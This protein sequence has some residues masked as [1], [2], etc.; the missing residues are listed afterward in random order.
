MGNFL[1]VFSTY[2]LEAPYLPRAIIA[3]LVC[4]ACMPIHPINR[5]RLLP[6]LNKTTIKTP[7]IF[8]VGHW[9]SGTTYLHQL[10]TQDPEFACVK[11]LQ[12]LAPNAPSNQYFLRNILERSI[13]KKRSIDNIQVS[14][15]APQE[16]DFQISCLS[17]NSFYHA[18]YFPK[19]IR[20]IF[21]KYVLFESFS[22]HAHVQAARRTW[23]KNYT[24]VLRHALVHAERDATLLLK[25]PSNTAR[26]DDLLELFPDAKFIHLYRNPY[27]VFPSTKNLY[28]KFQNYAFQSVDETTLEDDIFYIYQRL[29]GK[30]FEQSSKIPQGNLIHV[31]YEDLE[32]NPL[33]E[34][35]RIYAELAIPDFEN[36]SSRFE[37]HVHKQKHYK[38]NRYRALTKQEVDKIYQHWNFT[39]DQWQY[40]VPETSG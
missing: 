10:L 20:S 22:G 34:I 36:V 40:A 5:A 29:M 4:G 8:I 39:I 16:E 23:V 28:R 25:D 15:D 37:Q 18:Y 38:K 27:H 33:Q 3:S 12:C 13:P 11:L 14:L 6:E 19:H 26:I 35:R 17:K 21:E 2:G 1:K 9:R 24:Y 31:R 7:P 32:S 30:F